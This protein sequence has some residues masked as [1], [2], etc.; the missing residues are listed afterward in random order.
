MTRRVGKVLGRLFGAAFLVAALYLAAA[1]LGGLIPGRTAALPAGGDVQIGLLY[2]PIHVDF[3]LPATAET[4]AALSF[5]E[6]G[7]VDVSDA[8]IGYFI[9]GWGA[10]DFY[11]TTPEWAD[12]TARATLRAMTGDA[13][14]LRVDSVPPGIAFEQVPQLSLSEV[15]YTALLSEIAD[16]AAPE[17]VGVAAEG[18]RASAGFVEARGRFHILRTCNTWVGRVLREAGIPMGLWT[19]TPY[20][21]RLS[22]WRAGLG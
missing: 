6:A 20:A 19:P 4:R 5:A 3:L 8:G 12:M 13:S 18:H 21:V 10:R 17:L 11:T 15:Q 7:G 22:L 2:G 1:A 16:T 14:V 9:V